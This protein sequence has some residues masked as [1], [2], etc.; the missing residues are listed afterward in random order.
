[1]DRR[2]APPTRQLFFFSDLSNSNQLT[3]TYSQNPIQIQV[4]HTN[5]INP[6]GLI[7]R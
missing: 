1:M 4:S 6:H 2:I 5:D 3:T 7:I